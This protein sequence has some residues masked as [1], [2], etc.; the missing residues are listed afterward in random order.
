VVGVEVVQDGGEHLL[1]HLRELHHGV[2]VGARVGVGRA[3][4]VGE[5]RV[6]A[7]VGAAREHDG[8]MGREGL[9]VHA[10][11]HVAVPR[12]VQRHL[13]VEREQRRRSRCTPHTHIHVSACRWSCRVRVVSCVP[14]TARLCLAPAA[15]CTMRSPC[16][17][18]ITLLAFLHT[19]VVSGSGGGE[20]VRRCGG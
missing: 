18:I 10:E 16:T 2:G 4:A 1:T 7:E 9:P 14:F 5:E 11:A 8:P 20:D 12:V 17:A 6:G 3:E 15:V 19:R 13:K